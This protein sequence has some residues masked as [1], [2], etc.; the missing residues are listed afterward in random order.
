MANDADLEF[1][2]LAVGV[3]GHDPLTEELQAVH[4]RLDAASDMVA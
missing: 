3:S 4:L 1:G 2:G